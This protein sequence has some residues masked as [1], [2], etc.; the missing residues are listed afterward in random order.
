MEINKR[1]RLIHYINAALCVVGISIIFYIIGWM[2]ADN[3]GLVG[4]LG[5][6]VCLGGLIWS[7]FTFD[8]MS[9]KNRER[10]P[11]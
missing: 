7:T 3:N 4:T 6:I 11:K 2:R 9:K 8:Q 5:F 10:D 1:Q